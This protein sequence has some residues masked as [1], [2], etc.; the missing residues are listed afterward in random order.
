VAH[1]L[2]A[3]IVG[4]SM[5]KYQ[6]ICFDKIILCGSILSQD[7]PWETLVERN[8]FWLARNEYG[9]NDFWA[10]LGAIAL[11]DGGRSGSDGFTFTSPVLEQICLQEFRH[12]DYYHEINIE[13]RWLP[14]LKQ[15][16]LEF[17]VLYGRDV[18]S[19]DQLS[20]ILDMTALLDVASYHTG[21]GSASLDQQI[22][23]D[24]A[25]KWT[26]VNPAIYIF[27]TDILGQR[28]RVLGYANLM[29]LRAA[30]YDDVLAGKKRDKDIEPADLLPYNQPAP[31]RLYFM[32]IAIEQG[33]R[34]IGDGIYQRA[35]ERLLFAATN[36]LVQFRR[37][38][39]V[40]VTEIAAVAWTIEGER[41]CEFLGMKPVGNSD[42]DG[43]PIYQIVLN[44]AVLTRTDVFRGIR[45]L[46]LTSA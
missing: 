37:D 13:K 1:S 35:F 28:K 2:G 10:S 44:D 32:S 39:G 38:Y 45:D 24:L 21:A 20:W 42:P 40:V 31:T 23:D 25:L 43:R 19:P 12:G 33:A 8:Q 15:R 17:E 36:Q 4:H 46:V 11:P 16:S 7:F 3:Y 27:L 29:P 5:L 30:T 18:T 22:P 14:F 9:R 34:R 26:E 6:D 41:L